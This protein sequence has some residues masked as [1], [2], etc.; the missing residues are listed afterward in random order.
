MSEQRKE[1]EREETV[2]KK[3][4]FVRLTSGEYLCTVRTS[5]SRLDG[6]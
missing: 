5:V 3:W 2:N 1:G 4:S 6:R